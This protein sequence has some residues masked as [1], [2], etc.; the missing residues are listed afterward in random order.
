MR[1]VKLLS[2]ELQDAADEVTHLKAREAHLLQELKKRGELARQLMLEKD[3]EIRNLRQKLRADTN[4]RRKSDSGATM[5]SDSGNIEEV[6][7]K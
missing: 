5:T 4:T 1:A 3:D 6:S 2:A 7:L